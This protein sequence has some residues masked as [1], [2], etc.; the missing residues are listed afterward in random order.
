LSNL[1][2][3]SYEASRAA[4]KHRKQSTINWMMSRQCGKMGEATPYLFQGTENEIYV[5][6]KIKRLIKFLNSERSQWTTGSFLSSLISTI[7]WF[8]VGHNLDNDL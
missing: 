5:S 4:K 1:Q 7:A 2:T 3:A 6:Q 8:E